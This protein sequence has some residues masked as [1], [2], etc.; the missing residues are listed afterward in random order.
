MIGL[1]A[2]PDRERLLDL[3]HRLGREVVAPAAGDVDQKARFPHE[4]FAAFREHRLL[5]LY[6]PKALGGGGCTFAD[7]SAICHTLGQYCGSTAMI[8]AMHQIQAVCVVRHSS[9]ALESYL[10][11]LCDKQLL[12]GSATTEEGIGGDVRSSTC[13]VEASGDRFTITKRAPVISY[14]NETDDILVTARRNPDA[15]TSDQVILISRKAST[16][17]TQ[18]H[19]W[20]TLG[21]RGTCSLGFVLEGSGPVDH[22][23]PQ[24][25]A[26]IS[27]QTMHPTSHLLWSSLWLGI[28][29]DAVNLAR[30]FVR[31][32]ARKKPGTPPPSALRLAELGEAH[33]RMRAT[34]A[35][36][37]TEYE[38]KLDDREALS[39]PSFA[40]RMNNVKLTASE[41]VTDLVTQALRICGIAGYKSDSKFPL[42]RHLR[43]AH[44]AA[45]MINNDRILLANSQLHLMA[46]EE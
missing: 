31:A 4:A 46:R 29:T 8:F 17:L 10:R 45:L 28:A 22:I 21:M 14:G 33:N 20:D 25:Y 19:T 32:E 43:D 6:V 9:P 2:S 24:P 5:S 34:I 26:E 27:Q 38:S 39:S 1:P 44:G 13:A 40:I 41:A 12:L 35:A 36:G 37:V 23:L 15:A 18:T 42:G 3:A 30:A 11:E 7:L 16:K